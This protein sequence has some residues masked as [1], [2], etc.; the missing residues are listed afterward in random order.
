MS[1]QIMKLIANDWDD[2]VDVTSFGKSKYQKS[3]LICNHQA[4]YFFHSHFATGLGFKKRNYM[5]FSKPDSAIH[6]MH[7]IK[8]IFDPKKILNPYTCLPDVKN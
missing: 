8:P 4:I 3:L 2:K 6:L 7:Q 1:F 5:H